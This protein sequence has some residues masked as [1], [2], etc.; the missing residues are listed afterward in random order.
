MGLVEYNECTGWIDNAKKRHG[1]K[2]GNERMMSRLEFTQDN[3]FNADETALF[4]GAFPL[5]R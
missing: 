3:N 2:K 4:I 1:L 5:K